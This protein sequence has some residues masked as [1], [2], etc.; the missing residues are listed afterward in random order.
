[1]MPDRAGQI[2]CQRCL[3]P[4]SLEQELCRRCG[5]RLMLVVEPTSLRFEEESAAT[6]DDYDE[7]LL[8]RISSLESRLTRITDRL[9]RGLELLLRHARTSYFDHLLLETLIAALGE[10]RTVNPKQIEDRWRRRCDRDAD[11]SAENS[12]RDE[13]RAGII[14]SYTGA[15]GDEFA[16]LVRGGF[17]HIESGETA[18]GTRTL[19]RAAAL[20]P[21]NAPLNTFLGEHFL[22]AGKNT[23]ARHYLARAQSALPD[24]RRVCLLLGLACGDE[25]DAEQAR[26]F[27]G[28]AVRRGGASFAAHYALGRLSAAESDWESALVH[29]KRA[30]AARPSPEAHYVLGLVNYQ[31][32]R[33][34]TAHKHLLKSVEMDALYGE[35][36]YLLGLVRLRLGRTEEA[37]EAFEFAKSLLGGKRPSPLAKRKILRPE[38]FPAPSF[39]GSARQTK[40][41]LVTGGDDR[42]AAALH[43]DAFGGP[44]SR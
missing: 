26:D 15:E 27:L 36:F 10:S 29:F 43:E 12:R 42:L 7:H 40:R 13:T 37:R 34:R 1:M 41:R 17:A 22:R 16:R 21:S 19:E 28:R 6:G 38:D 33:F 31:L 4:N 11:A 5:T 3:A 20:A 24:D 8:E 44:P 2:F 9:E 32:G 35:A 18:R 39:F 30:R 23:L 14:A 25:G